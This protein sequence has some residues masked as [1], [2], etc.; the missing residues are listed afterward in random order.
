MSQLI[1]TNASVILDSN[2]ISD[3]V[4]SCTINYKKE[5]IEDTAMGDSS[6]SRIGGLEDWSIDLEIN[7]DYADNDID[8]ILYGLVSGGVGYSVAIK[9]VAT[10]ISTSNPAW[11]GTGISESYSPISGKVGDLSKTSF[12]IMSCGTVLVRDVTP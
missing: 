8:E 4:T 10:T 11:T 7:N 2:D 1:L 12:T 9:P 3:H 5:L 6:R